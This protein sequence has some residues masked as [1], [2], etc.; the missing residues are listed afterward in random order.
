MVNAARRICGLSAA[1]PP[2][3]VIFSRRRAQPQCPLILDSG[4]CHAYFGHIR[5]VPKRGIELGKMN[6]W[7]DGGER[8]GFKQ[9]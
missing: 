4:N 3:R 6:V 9:E 7:E 2:L 8:Q 5:L 1:R